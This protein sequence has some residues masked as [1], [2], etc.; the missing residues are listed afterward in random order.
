LLA[1]ALAASHG[2]IVLRW[3]VEEF[4]ERVFWR[5][6]TEERQVQKLRIRGSENVGALRERSEGKGDGRELRGGFWNGG[7]EG[8]R[9]IA[10]VGKV[11]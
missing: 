3:A 1:I 9:E 2:F 5:G 4:V 6:S 8:A 10:R 11:E 7:E